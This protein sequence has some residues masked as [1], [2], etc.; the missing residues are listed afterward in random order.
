MTAMQKLIE[1]TVVS[2]RGGDTNEQVPLY[3]TATAHSLC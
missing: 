2:K 1:H 3:V